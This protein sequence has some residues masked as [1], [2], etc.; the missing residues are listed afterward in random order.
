MICTF[1]YTRFRVEYTGKPKDGCCLAE[2]EDTNRMIVAGPP[3][4]ASH[5]YP[6]STVTSVDAPK[7]VSAYTTLNSQADA[8]VF[9]RTV[10][11]T[12]AFGAPQQR[13]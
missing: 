13:Y 2:I 3:E 12:G 10:S 7:G 11:R 9:A 4:H 8:T 1:L 5:I 6:G